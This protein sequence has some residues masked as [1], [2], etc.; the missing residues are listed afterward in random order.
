[1]YVYVLCVRDKYYILLW[2]IYHDCNE[3]DS[4]NRSQVP[5]FRYLD[6]DIEALQ[7]ARYVIFFW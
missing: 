6:T 2:H 4:Q 7:F 5:W 3:G 1:M